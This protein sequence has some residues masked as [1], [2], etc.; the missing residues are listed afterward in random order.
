MGLAYS[1]DPQNTRL[2][3]SRESLGEA[4][5]VSNLPTPRKPPGHRPLW[6]TGVFP[7]GGCF[8]KHR[9][10]GCL[11][12]RQA[13]LVLG[14]WAMASHAQGRLGREEFAEGLSGVEVDGPA[15]GGDLTN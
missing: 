5:P 9:G 8:R 1:K 3:G 15:I 12:S 6:Q 13:Y 10:E 11:T 7:L 14:V 2:V 4:F